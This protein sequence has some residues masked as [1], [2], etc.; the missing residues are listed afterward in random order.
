MIVVELSM[1]AKCEQIL[2]DSDASRKLHGKI[3]P[4][5]YLATIGEAWVVRR[6]NEEL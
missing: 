1:F 3:F 5:K 4:F 2:K 6:D